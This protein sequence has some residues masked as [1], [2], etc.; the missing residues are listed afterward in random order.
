MGFHCSTM[1]T[2]FLAPFCSCNIIPNPS[3]YC[4]KT[5]VAAEFL[6]ERNHHFLRN[7]HIFFTSSATHTLFHFLRNTHLFSKEGT[8]GCVRNLSTQGW[9]KRSWGEMDGHSGFVCWAAK[10]NAC[11]TATNNSSSIRNLESKTAAESLEATTAVALSTLLHRTLGSPQSVEIPN[12]YKKKTGFHRP[13]CWKELRVFGDLQHNSEQPPPQSFPP[14]KNVS[15]F[16]QSMK[17][18][19]GIDS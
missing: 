2:K 17:V 9:K 16:V 15:S 4:F 12:L 14:V 3:N 11:C 13:T 7:K 8:S 10:A 1:D 5:P 18:G 6:A 19:G